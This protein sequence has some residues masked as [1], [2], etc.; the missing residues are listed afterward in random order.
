M[1][2][3]HYCEYTESYT[4]GP[5]SGVVIND[6]GN[7]EIWGENS[8]SYHTYEYDGVFYSDSLDYVE[9]VTSRYNERHANMRWNNET[10]APFPTVAYFVDTIEQ[11]PQFLIDDGE[12]EVVMHDD[13]RAFLLGYEDHYPIARDRFD[14]ITDSESESVA[15]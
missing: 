6:R 8:I 11:I 12:V 1:N 7:T 13:G 14:I 2:D 5:V 15:A 4:F 9:V 3:A 10:R